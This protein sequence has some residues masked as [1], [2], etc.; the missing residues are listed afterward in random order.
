[1]ELPDRMVA[2]VGRILKGKVGDQGADL[3]DGQ[4]RLLCG[5]SLRDAHL[6]AVREDWK[7]M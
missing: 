5:R 3:Q 4:N 2:L 6:S 7:C 1:M